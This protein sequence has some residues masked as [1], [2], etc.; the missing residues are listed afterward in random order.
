MVVYHHNR[1]TLALH[2][3]ISRTGVLL[4]QAAFRLAPLMNFKGFS[5]RDKLVTP[6]IALRLAH[7]MLTA[8]I[9]RR[10]AL[11]ALKDIHEFGVGNPFPAWHG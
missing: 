7:Q 10:P 3:L 4:Y 11:E 5:G 8:K 2:A 6:L 9:G 1:E